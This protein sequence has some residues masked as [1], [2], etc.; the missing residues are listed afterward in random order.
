MMIKLAAAFLLDAVFGDPVWLYHPIRVIGKW[1]SLMEKCLRRCFPVNQR[2]E[3]LAGIFLVI[4]VVLPSFFLTAGILC[5]AGKLHPGLA[6]ALEVFWMYQILAMKCL[7]EE[8][9]KE[10]MHTLRMSA[11]DYV[12]D[13]TTSFSEMVKV[14]FDV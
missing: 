7:K 2:G 10:G 8:A 5:L 6:F 11:T 12:L 4:L 9:L 14:S 3:R 13:G 1:I